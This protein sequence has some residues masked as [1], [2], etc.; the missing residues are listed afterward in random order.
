MT[1]VRKSRIRNQSLVQRPSTLTHDATE[2][3]EPEN[4]N[5]YKGKAQG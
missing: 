3:L 4:D 2:G 5:H 1:K